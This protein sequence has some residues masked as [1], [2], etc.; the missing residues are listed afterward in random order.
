MEKGRPFSFGYT[1]GRS[2]FFSENWHPICI[3]EPAYRSADASGQ[4]SWPA[5]WSFL[6]RRCPTLS[7]KTAMKEAETYH[8][9][10]AFARKYL[11]AF[12][13]GTRSKCGRIFWLVW[14]EIESDNTH[15]ASSSTHKEERREEREREISP[16][17]LKIDCSY[18]AEYL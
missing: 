18:C 2:H 14:A 4:L 3:E 7:P 8:S 15:D 11:P 1:F 6:C 16:Q 5:S 12:Y 17:H 10:S 13:H 9:H